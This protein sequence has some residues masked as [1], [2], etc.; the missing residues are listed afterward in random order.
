MNEEEDDKELRQK[1]TKIGSELPEKDNTNEPFQKVPS[2]SKKGLG[3]KSWK[4]RTFSM[5]F[6]DR[7][8]LQFY[9]DKRL[10]Q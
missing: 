8:N 10:K 6:Q 4:I 2:T 5:T 3:I 1:S 7:T 9:P